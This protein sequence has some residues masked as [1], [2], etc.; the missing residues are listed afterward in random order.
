MR[1]PVTDFTYPEEWVRVCRSEDDRQLAA[2]G[3]G[4]LTS[5]G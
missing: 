5:S 1:D 4:V 3:L 2:S